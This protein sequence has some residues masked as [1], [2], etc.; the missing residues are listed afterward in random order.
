MF[1]TDESSD[2][3]SSVVGIARLSGALLAQVGSAVRLSAKA[4]KRETA[5]RD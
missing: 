2:N 1:V 4:T 5:E 3:E